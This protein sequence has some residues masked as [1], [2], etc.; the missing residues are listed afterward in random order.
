LDSKA[1]PFGWHDP[2][3]GINYETWGNNVEAGAWPVA[4]VL[5]AESPNGTFVYEYEPDAK[6]PF[7]TYMAG[8][9]QAFYITNMLHDL[10]YLL[11]FTPAAGNYQKN[12]NGEGGAGN[13]PVRV[14]LQA[15]GGMNNGKFTQS[16]D[17]SAG[18]LTMYLFDKTDPQR[19]SAFD[20]GFLMH[21]Y[22]HGSK[23]T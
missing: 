19:D 1:S 23:Y 7:D 15:L 16:N 21:E 11:G 13:D 4:Q 2:V 9:T 3:N 8:V 6:P 18:T 5:P 20:S 22:T 10:Y 17:G 12:N 14:L